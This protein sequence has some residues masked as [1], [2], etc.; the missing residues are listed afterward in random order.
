MRLFTMFFVSTALITSTV[1]AEVSLKRAKEV[2]KAQALSDAKRQQLRARITP[3]ANKADK[4]VAKKEGQRATRLA[5]RSAALRAAAAVSSVE[6]DVRLLMTKRGP[7]SLT[8]PGGMISYGAKV[9]GS[10]RV[11]SAMFTEERSGCVIV[12]SELAADRRTVSNFSNTLE[13]FDLPADA[14]NQPCYVEVFA[15]IDN[16]GGTYFTR[17]NEL[18]AFRYVKGRLE[19]KPVIAGNVGGYAVDSQNGSL[20]IAALE[21]TRDG[22]NLKSFLWKSDG[23]MAE[24]KS[25]DGD[26]FPSALSPDGKTALVTIFDAKGGSAAGIVTSVDTTNYSVVKLPTPPEFGPE[27]PALISRYAEASGGLNGNFEVTVGF[28]NKKYADVSLEDLYDIVLRTYRV[29]TEKRELTPF[30]VK[31]IDRDT[32]ESIVKVGVSSQRYEAREM[33]VSYLFE[34]DGEWYSEEETS[35][36]IVDK[37]TGKWVYTYELIYGFYVTDFGWNVLALEERAGEILLVN[38]SQVISIPID[39]WEAQFR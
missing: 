39:L 6:P 4:M 2:I 14:E 17:N 29:N 37:T 25:P 9:I 30:P 35:D 16:F 8:L 5:K 11:Q 36:V 26:V 23:T 33:R 3:A 21:Y 24:L 7:L 1:Y 20:L 34:E 13:I 10:D 18:A 28:S 19:S 32:F 22:A 27:A 15:D 31:R 38:S 12:N